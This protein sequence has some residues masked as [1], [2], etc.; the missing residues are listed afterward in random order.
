MGNGEGVVCADNV[1]RALLP[2]GG[3]VTIIQVVTGETLVFHD[4]VRPWMPHVTLKE[5]TQ[6]APCRFAN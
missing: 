4:T 5:G 6:S 1:V 3:Q 2:V